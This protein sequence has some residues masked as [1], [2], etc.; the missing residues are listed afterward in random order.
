MAYNKNVKIEDVNS[1]LRRLF[2]DRYWAMPNTPEFPIC[3]LYDR[4]DGIKVQTYPANYMLME[5][6]EGYASDKFPWY[7]PSLSNAEVEDRLM[8]REG[9]SCFWDADK[10]QISK[11]N[12]MA[13]AYLEASVIGKRL[14]MVCHGI[15]K[16]PKELLND[17]LRDTTIL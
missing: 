7:L 4:V 12:R 13:E 16:N 5:L 9:Q 8:K 11:V 17:I 6:L 2:G 14:V 10:L 15:N 1:L 3:V